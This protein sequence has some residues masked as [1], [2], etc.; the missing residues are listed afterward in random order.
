MR[1]RYRDWGAIEKADPSPL[2]EISELTG[3][4]IIPGDLPLQ[5]IRGIAF[6]GVILQCRDD[7]LQVT[8]TLAPNAVGEYVPSGTFEDK[9]M[10]AVNVPDPSFVCYYNASAKTYVIAATVTDGPLTSFWRPIIPITNPIGVYRPH[11]SYTGVAAVDDSPTDLSGF[12]AEAQIRRNEQDELVYDLNPTVTNAVG[13]EI[14]IPPVPSFVTI[15]F[16][17]VGS[18]HWDLILTDNVPNRFGPYISSVFTIVDNF[19]Q[20]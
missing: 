7:I 13:G 8:G 5:F 16:E 17:N 10:Y 2:Q 12:S 3:K 1:T 18:Y 4:A 20:L 19:T 6:P 9:P 15:T 14:T 11:G